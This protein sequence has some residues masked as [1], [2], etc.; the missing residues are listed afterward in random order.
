MDTVET[1]IGN[2]QKPL[3]LK[4]D[5]EAIY[6]DLMRDDRDA[7]AGI[8]NT[9]FHTVGRHMLINVGVIDSGCRELIDGAVDQG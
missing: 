3:Y 7:D 4:D 5:P 9:V 8:V 6:Y 2:K 1:K